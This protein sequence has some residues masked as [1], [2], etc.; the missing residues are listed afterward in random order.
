VD[1]CKALVV[2]VIGMSLVARGA[3]SIYWGSSTTESFPHVTGVLSIMLSW[4]LSPI[5]SGVCAALLFV[6][7][8]STVLRT[9]EPF[10][11]ALIAFPVVVGCTM[12]INVYFLLV[13]GTSTAEHTGRGLH[14]SPSQ[15]NTSNSL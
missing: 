12:T 15:L 13:K 5:L 2:G 8:R 3:S 1:E 9:S 6:I 14:S 10:R 7:I 11:N 4:M